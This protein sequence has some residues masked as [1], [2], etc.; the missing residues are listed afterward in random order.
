MRIGIDI[1]GVII[2][3]ANDGTD[4]SFFGDNFLRTTPVAGV[5]E[6]I[7]ALV[8]SGADCYIVSKA[9]VKTQ[10]RSKLWLVNQEFFRKT[11][12]DPEH[13]HFCRE[14]HEKAPIA[15]R[16][17]L[18]HFIDD[19]LEVLGYLD[20]VPNK[21]LLNSTKGEVRR[22]SHHLPKVKLHATWQT[23]VEDILK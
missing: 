10:E 9:G 1:G 16:L 5:F 14:R 3:R 8:D 15:Q 4:T 20:T 18:T 12:F 21:Y 7:K 6:G 19:K 23:V 17:K 2:D 11:G 13:I 22:Y